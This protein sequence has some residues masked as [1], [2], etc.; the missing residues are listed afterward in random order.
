ML[1]LDEEIVVDSTNLIIMM[2]HRCNHHQYLSSLFNL[3]S[4]D[5]PWVSNDRPKA[6]RSKQPSRTPTNSAF[7][8][9]W[10]KNIR[11]EN[12]MI[13]MLINNHMILYHIIMMMPISKQ[14]PLALGFFRSHL[15]CL[16]C[17]PLYNG[18]NLLGKI[19]TKTQ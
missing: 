15:P 6:G 9:V 14:F 16:P 12:L 17:D 2:L 1:E 8:L 18:P 5:Q 19:K 11:K 3:P 7:S 4:K 13:F 10:V